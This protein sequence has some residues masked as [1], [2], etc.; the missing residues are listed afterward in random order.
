MSYSMFIIAHIMSTFKGAKY[1]SSMATLTSGRKSASA[2]AIFLQ[3]LVNLS[4]K[5]EDLAHF[6]KRYESYFPTDAFRVEEDVEEVWPLSDLPKPNPTETMQEIPGKWV[7]HTPMTA[8]RKV[9]VR[10]RI[11]IKMREDL[12]RVWEIT[13]LRRKEWKLFLLR[14]AFHQM[15]VCRG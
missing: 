4:D 9:A 6:W 10:H 14:E 3:W 13:D 11:L 7:A 12:R 5:P 8:E 1:M 2:L 15:S